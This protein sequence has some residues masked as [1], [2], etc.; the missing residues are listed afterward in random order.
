MS[1]DF[2][3]SAESVRVPAWPLRTDRVVLMAYSGTRIAFALAGA[4]ALAALSGC[5]SGSSMGS[6]GAGTTVTASFSGATMP[7]AVAY[8]SGAS[9][10]FKALALSGSSS[11]SFTLPSGTTAYGFA[12]MCPTFAAVN[13]YSNETIIQATTTDTTSLSL[14]CPS[15][16]GNVS[17]TF[18]VS[19][20]PG[21][22]SVMLYVNYWSDDLIYLSQPTGSVG[23]LGIPT[24]TFD[25]ALVAEGANGALAIQILRGVSVTG[26]TN[27]AFPPMTAADELGS[28]PAS[29]T[30][31]PSGT[32]AGFETTYQTSGGLSVILNGPPT[33]VPQSTYLTAPSSQSQSGDFYLIRAV[34]NLAQPSESLTAL[35]SSSTAS[36]VT[37]ALPAPS[38]LLT[39][40]MAAAF[41]TF[42]A[43]T[44]G[45]TV[46]GTIVDASWTQFQTPAVNQ[47]VY[48]VYTYVTKNWLGTN[49]TFTV[50]DLSALPGFAP[51]PPSGGREFWSLYST[52]GTP[53]QFDTLQQSAIETFTSP[54]SLQSIST[55]GYFA[56]P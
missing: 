31:V 4:L 33:A 16:S 45:F 6:I 24:G 7:S 52:A 23:L 5:G 46:Q 2:Q 15:L 48:N 44:S 47:T 36:A 12:Y 39:A 21:A 42:N 27:V 43:N 18:D 50:P 49:T 17:A 55:A 29:I 19:A 41:P 56:V 9:G 25:V 37:A 30:N 51:A 14:A 53:L 13:S 40:P 8:Q 22:T 11:V 10:T 20:I 32:T 26:S 28:A 1:E 38:S 34:A 35:V 3:L 54:I